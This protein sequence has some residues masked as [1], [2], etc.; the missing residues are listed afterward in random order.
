M[1]RIVEKG[2]KAKNAKARK[3]CIR[4]SNF[5]KVGEGGTKR[6]MTEPTGDHRPPRASAAPVRLKRPPSERKPVINIASSNQ[7]CVRA[8]F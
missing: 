5:N 4:M 1:C 6:E 7:I 3:K 8:L 2:S